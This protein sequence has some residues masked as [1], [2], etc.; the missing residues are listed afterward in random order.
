VTRVHVGMTI[1]A[2]G[3]AICGLAALAGRASDKGAR[4]HGD[5]EDRKGLAVATVA[6]MLVGI[7]T[8]VGG[9]G[10]AVSSAIFP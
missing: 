5:A 9:F 3:V 2:G 8:V 7:V 1:M 10:F 6:L 4:E